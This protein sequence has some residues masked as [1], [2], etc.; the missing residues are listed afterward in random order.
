MS[1]E[2]LAVEIAGIKMN[3]PVMGASGT[4]G[5]GM[6]YQ[7]FLNL[8][9]VG[10]VF[11]KGITPQPRAGNPGVRIAETPSA[12]LNSIGLENPGLEVF[13][14]DILPQAAQL[15]TAFIVNISAGTVEEY[16][17]MAAALDV[18][19][20]DGLEVNISC[21]NVKEGGIV[22]GTDPKAAAAVTASVKKHTHKPVIVKL[23]PNVTSI[24]TMAQAVEAAGADGISLINTIMGMAIDIRRRRPLL[25]NITGGMSGP[26]VK[27]IALRMVWQAAQ[28]V[29]IPVIGLGGITSAEDAI[30]FL[31]A[32][33]SGVQVG[34]Q[35]FQ[36]P[37]VI[38]K[39]TQGLDEYLAQN[40]LQHVSELV[41]AL[42][43]R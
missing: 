43:V 2:R 27:P 39:I 28:A 14:R 9:E 41:G 36:D 4:F 20:V 35:N 34:A 16:G 33:A 6:E 31:L 10:A 7:D 23:S 11:S 19:G 5:F 22:F 8:H 3:T 21:P 18:D 17:E 32:G 40:G 42:K 26:A 38:A 30:E 24:A 29:R 37:G 12:M 25:G 13:K 1:S 15:P